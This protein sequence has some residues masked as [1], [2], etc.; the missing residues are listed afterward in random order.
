VATW[1][2]TIRDGIESRRLP[3]LV[4]VIQKTVRTHPD[5]GFRF[6]RSGTTVV[7]TLN[8]AELDVAARAVAVHLL[9]EGVEAG[10]RA[11]LAF[12]PGL[13][14]IRAFWGCV[15]A[16]VVP[17]PALPP[18]AIRRERTLGRLQKISQDCQ[19]S[20]VL[21][22]SDFPSHGLELG[23]VLTLAQLSAEPERWTR[24]DTGS[25]TTALLQ[26]TSGS[27]RH[28][29][30]VVTSHGNII[31]NLDML[32]SFH[33][34]MD[35]MVMVHW[36]PLF[37]DMGLI[38]GMLSPLQMGAD[39]YL[40]DPMEFVQRPDC[41]LKA[42][43]HFRA[44]ITGAPNFGYE[45]ATR[46]VGSETRESL[47]L[48]SLKV[49]FCSAEPIRSSTVVRFLE[50]FAKCGLSPQTF[51]PS[52]GLAEATVAVSGELGPRYR[53]CEVNPDDARQFVSSGQVLGDLELQI[54]D[55]TSRPCAV[56]TIGEIW[57]RGPSIARGYWNSPTEESPFECYLAD[58]EGPFLRTGDLGFLD[59]EGSLYITG[60]KKDLIIIRGQ[61]F[62]PQDL[63]ATLEEDIPELRKGC[64]AVFQTGE[65]I[66]V[67]CESRSHDMEGLA[68]S[69]RRVV[70]EE[71]GLA[72]ALVTVLPLGT[73]F[74]T[75][76]GKMQ[77]TLTRKRCLEGNFRHLYRWTRPG[78]PEPL[79]SGN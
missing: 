50:G 72:V 24:P 46:K 42:V 16:G 38:R 68:Q 27:T 43:S 40:M 12:R 47:D 44:T 54:V 70:G 36:L 20:L 1:S 13:D 65:R 76:S 52:Y 22:D 37:H 56:R 14:F 17:V 33:G 11:L 2:R 74:K 29:R 45:M 79:S 23:P 48:S 53:S 26:Y 63:E 60:R 62:Y 18:Q 21:A 3:T 8:Y 28:P 34:E 35:P 66:G 49:A 77:R 32:R 19:S 39:C 6:V 78:T 9:D 67:A 25:E 69:V 41:W 7:E 15:Y 4:D 61:N 10:S 59:R 30:G 51:K 31:A 71:F 64:T 73:S 58:G 57:L 75:S 5:R 55:E